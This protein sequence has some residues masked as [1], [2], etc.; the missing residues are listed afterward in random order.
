MRN[1]DQMAILEEIQTRVQ[2]NRGEARSEI[3]GDSFGERT[4]GLDRVCFENRLMRA[5]YA[6]RQ[7]FYARGV[8]RSDLQ[9]LSRTII[10]AKM[11][12]LAASNPE[13]GCIGVRRC[14]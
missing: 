7:V 2:S 13:S 11:I 14:L 1:R 4:N 6:N 10:Q 9:N 3:N 12:P 8:R 5:A